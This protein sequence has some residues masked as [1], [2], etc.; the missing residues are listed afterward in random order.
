MDNLFIF[1][2]FIND[3]HLKP[4]ISIFS[5]KKTLVHRYSCLLRGHYIKSLGDRVLIWWTVGNNK[6][7]PHTQTLLPTEVPLSLDLQL[8]ILWRLLQTKLPPV[9]LRTHKPSSWFIIIIFPK[10]DNNRS[11]CYWPFWLTL[12]LNLI[13]NLLDAH[14]YMYIYIYTHK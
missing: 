8:Q 3:I 13:F 14:R 7:I 6:G 11:F 4:K 5:I 10:T 1:A 9:T 2:S 12:I